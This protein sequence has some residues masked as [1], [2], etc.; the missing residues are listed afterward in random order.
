VCPNVASHTIDTELTEI[1]DSILERENKITN[2]PL[3]PFDR[4]LTSEETVMIELKPG[5]GVS[6]LRDTTFTEGDAAVTCEIGAAEYTLSTSGPS[7]VAMIRSAERG[8]YVAG[9]AAEVG[10]GGHLMAPLG[11][12]QSLKFGLFDDMNGYYF[13]ILYWELFVVVLK[14]GVE[15]R[16]NR[17]DFNIDTMDGDGASK[18]T[19]DP[20]RGYIWMIRFSWYGYGIVEFA[21]AAEDPF[22]EQHIYPMHRY[23]SKVRASVSTPNLP[24]TAKLESSPDCAPGAVGGAHITG[25][26]YSVLGKFTPMIRSGSAYLIRSFPGGAGTVTPVMSIRRKAGYLSA[27]VTLDA[28]EGYSESATVVIQI[29]TG[30]ELTGA[31]WGTVPD[32]TPGE[33]AVE[34]DD[35]ATAASGGIVVHQGFARYGTGASLTDAVGFYLTEW[36]AVTVLVKG[37]AA[38]GTMNIGL[39]WNEEF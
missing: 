35:S 36:D 8:R 25:R 11:P 3:T 30:M 17:T 7:A 12:G 9:M 10:I 22:K 26:K 37:A 27:P 38:A 15:T 39:R 13:E 34:Y 5:L 24:I 29:R 21:I 1:T 32:A 6:K 28:L 2:L 20:F 23:Y 4:M 19:L 31:V 14:D 33:T 16:V 18:I